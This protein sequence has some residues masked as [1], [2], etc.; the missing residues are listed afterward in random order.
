M[1]PIYGGGDAATAATSPTWGSLDSS[2]KLCILSL[3]IGLD[4]FLEHIFSSLLVSIFYVSA[5]P[6]IRIVAT[7][8][9]YWLVIFMTYIPSSLWDS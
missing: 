2:H 9:G 6:V 3:L 1:R 4:D 8:P 7:Q 5:V